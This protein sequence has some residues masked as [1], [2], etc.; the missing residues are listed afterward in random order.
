M[1]QR[2]RG[3]GVELKRLER[4]HKKRMIKNRKLK[5]EGVGILKREAKYMKEKGEVKKRF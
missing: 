2:E 5:K 3:G 1:G 4:R